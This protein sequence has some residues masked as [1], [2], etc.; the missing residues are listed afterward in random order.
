MSL[1][2]EDGTGLA[3][4]NSFASVAEADAYHAGH[5]YASTWTAAVT[6]TKEKA[7]M[8]ATRILDSAAKWV[9]R[10]TFPETQALGWPRELA[11]LDGTLLAEN[12]VPMPVKNATAELARL[13]IGEDLTADPAQNGIKS[14][15]LGKGALVI[16]FRED[17]K[18]KQIP[19][20]VSTL[21]MGLGTLPNPG[22]ITQRQ[23][24][25][26]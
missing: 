25:R 13:L 14:L 7:L 5:L 20:M 3:D 2:V 15:D 4:A 1:I 18:K 11:Y 16:E 9:G 10:R 24:Y 12:A 22:G 8:M 26:A 17:V 6:G 23:I 21:L 19:T